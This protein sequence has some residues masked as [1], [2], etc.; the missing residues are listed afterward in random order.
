LT[1]VTA[2]P[3]FDEPHRAIAERLHGFA[4]DVIEPRAGAADTGEPVAVGRQFVRDAAAHG[5]L[6][7]FVAGGGTDGRKPDLRALCLAREA[8]A[9]ASAFADSVFAVHGLGTFPIALAGEATLRTRYLRGALDGTAIGAFAVT[10]SEAGSDPAGMET[11]ARR[12]G[13]AYVIDGGKT[14][15][16]NAGLA[17][18]YVVFARTDPDAGRKGISAFVV[19]ADTPGF[20]VVRQIAL[21][22]SHPIGELAFEAC[23]VPLSHRLGADGEGLKI[24][25]TTL[26][27]FRS[28]VG[29][30]AC[31]M[32]QR[33]LDEA[34]GRAAARRQFGTRVADF[35]MTRAAIADMAME[36]D[37]ARLLVYRAAW[38]KDRGATRVT[39]EAA[40]AKL[41]ATEAAQR[42]IDRAVQIHGGI[43]VQRGVV[44][45]RL[46]REIR[47]LRI[48]EGTSEIQR[49]I[50]AEQE[51]GRS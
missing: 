3:F 51:V 27:F 31:G 18:F 7:L 12:D 37:A 2:L 5:V 17:T 44:V 38:T 45:E 41:Y 25:L 13:D 9:G 23:R 50:I 28:S 15:I 26:D 43:G 34:V 47:A 40:M 4:R 35:Q 48:Y 11:R 14:L 22:A 6:S 39:R 21:M 36:L 46:Y 10:E 8:I 16:S 33:A 29:A 49:L 24:A 30:A 42:I 20:R 1:D 32:A 19:D